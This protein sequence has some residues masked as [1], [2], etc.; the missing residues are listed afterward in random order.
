MVTTLAVVA[1]VLWFP[2]L[3]WFLVL[4]FREKGWYS[5]FKAITFI[6]E[7]W[8][9][10]RRPVQMM[11]L[12]AISAA[13]GGFLSGYGVGKPEES[14]CLRACKIALTGCAG[15]QFPLN[16]EQC[17]AWCEEGWGKEGDKDY[18]VLRDLIGESDDKKSCSTMEFEITEL[19]QRRPPS[20]MATPSEAPTA[21]PPG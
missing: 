9:V 17:A 13:I 8:D 6:L 20:G 4:L 21:L 12:G 16:P 19:F 14:R 3:I 10:V 15:V 7:S 18:Y 11:I 2:G 5:P 1:G